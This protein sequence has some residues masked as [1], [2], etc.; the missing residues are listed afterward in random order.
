MTAEEHRRT[1]ALLG[2]AAI[3]AI[4][5]ALRA[6][7]IDDQPLWGDEA[8]TLM[9][10]QW[11][12]VALFTVPND[13]TPGLYYA[14]HKLLI[15]PHAGVVAARSISLVAGTATIIATYA[16]AKACRISALP[17]AAF[18]ALS[19]ALVDYSQE[20]RAYSLLVLFVALSGW[21][22]VHWIRKRRL[23][24]GFLEFP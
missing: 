11:P 5:F 14:L 22:F 4:G 1:P 9:I 10:A 15:G 3:V 17:A 24:K 18:T 19:F 12:L 16:W 20:A 2:L 8:L 6:V 7:N 23:R 21:A 13:P